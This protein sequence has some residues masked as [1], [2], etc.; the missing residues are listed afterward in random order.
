M[1]PCPECGFWLIVPLWA[2]AC[3][4]CDAHDLPEGE[5][6]DGDSDA[7]QRRIAAAIEQVAFE[8]MQ[9]RKVLEAK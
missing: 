3:P 2:R 1:T 8:I 6:R 7:V 9:L 4:V 5:I